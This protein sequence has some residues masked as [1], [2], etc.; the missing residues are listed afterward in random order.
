MV[1]NNPAARTGMMDNFVVDGWSLVVL[2]P[3]MMEGYLAALA[4]ERGEFVVKMHPIQ[5]HES[6]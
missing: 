5:G 2:G 4:V 1:L 3:D 6:Q